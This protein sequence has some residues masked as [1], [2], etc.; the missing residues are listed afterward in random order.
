MAITWTVW[1]TVGLAL[2]IGLVASASW[3]LSRVRHLKPL[4]TRPRPVQSYAEALARLEQLTANVYT[5]DRAEIKPP[6]VTRLFLHDKKMPRALVFFHGFT[7]CPQQFVQLSER[8]HQQGCNVII[9]RMP[10]HGMKDRKQMKHLTAE[11]LAML[12]DDA[13]DIAQGL[14]DEVVVV[15]LS[16]GG[17]LAT[18]AA[19]FRNDVDRVVIIA[20]WLSVPFAPNW[21]VYSVVWLVLVLPDFY[22]W[23]DPIRREKRDWGV[24]HAY[25][26]FSSHAMGQMMRLGATVLK[27]SRTQPPA[28]R[29]VV[30]VTNAAD[31][32]VDNQICYEIVGRWQ[33]NGGNIT[34]YEFPA[35]LK[36]IHDCIDPVQPQEQVASVYPVLYEL[37]DT[38]IAI[39]AASVASLPRLS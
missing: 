15:G 9:P 1:H 26:G 37:I 25:P 31:K 28:A 18:W 11:D 23:W 29:S 22:V 2:L 17:T 34:S 38:P 19:Q 14:G 6:C 32:T 20:P 7:N 3:R 33:A 35:E 36:L 13:I 21:L 27:T 39:P 5:T 12:L 10:F 8:Y 4:L 24:P 16:G 30:M